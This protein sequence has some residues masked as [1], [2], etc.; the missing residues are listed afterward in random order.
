[1]PTEED[2]VFLGARQLAADIGAGELSAREVLDAHL[3]RIE[4]VNPAVNAIV[5]LIADRA[6][7]QA[8][9]ADQL[10]AS[11]GPLGP[12]HGVPIAHKDTN[13]TAGIRTTLGSP[14]FADQIPDHDDLVVARLRAAGAISMGKTNVPEFGAGAH[15]FNPL[16]GPTRNPYALDRSA[17]GSSGGAAAAVATGMQPL[18]DGSDFGGSL[19]FPASFCNVV[20]LRPS[21]GRVPAYPAALG[22]A[23]LP[24]DGPIAR[25]VADVAFGLSVMAGPDDR[26]PLSLPEPGEVFSAALDRDPAGLRVAY[27]TDLGGTLPVDPEVR[28][29]IAAAAGVF[30]RLG[31]HVT[32]DCPDL[33]GANDCFRT[34]RAAS[35]AYTLGPLV[36][37]H[38]G[39]IKQTVVENVAAGRRL[40][41][42]DIMAAQEQ[43]TTLYRRMRAFF[44]S[45][46]VLALPVS[47]LPPFDVDLEFPTEIDGTA[48]PHY[49]DWMRSCTDI[50]ATGLPALS[51]PAGFTRDG[52]PVGL[53]L[54]GRWHGDFDLLQIGHAFE[55]AT[56]HGQHRPRM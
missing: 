33:S 14:V 4:R 26:S 22:W 40:S 17:G 23:W 43:R 30:E 50:S 51:V 41:A 34:L 35:F 44:D 11:G 19:R 20:G 10:A 37:A 6:M 39:L 15:T 27:S 3:R 2:L 47:Q 29:V 13:M 16:F 1:M 56:Q 31:A 42:A 7:E 45:Y 5:T 8:V 36:D 48:T 52:L 25:T 53:Q 24:V 9:R 38:P 21:A 18:A 55:Q 12:L 28:A 32:E 54:V 49:L 46:D